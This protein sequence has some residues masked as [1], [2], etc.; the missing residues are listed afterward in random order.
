VVSLFVLTAALA[1]L[2]EKRSMAD[3]SNAFTAAELRA[4]RRTFESFGR[5]VLFALLHIGLILACLALAFLADIPV[6]S[7][8][9]WIGGTVAMIAVFA[10]TGS[11][12]AER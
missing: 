7:L 3:A 2:D 1:F 5:L 8:A 6:I 9:M 4:H 10:I 11:Y 12:G